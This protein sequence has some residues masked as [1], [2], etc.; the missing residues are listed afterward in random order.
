MNGIYTALVAELIW[1]SCAL[2]GNLKFHYCA[3]KP[4]ERTTKE[5]L[6]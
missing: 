2:N 1:E 5:T 6:T 3:A 4:Q